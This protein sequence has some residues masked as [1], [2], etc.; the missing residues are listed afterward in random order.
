MRWLSRSF[1]LRVGWLIPALA[2]LTWVS[3]SVFSNY[4][5][6]QA[7]RSANRG[8][9]P[10]VRVHLGRFLA[11]H[12]SDAKARL[13]LAEAFLKDEANL[14]QQAAADAAL[15]E[16]ERI[17]DAS[18]HGPR[19]R[20]QEARLRLFVLH[21][22][23]AAEERLRRAILLDPKSG[24]APYLLWKLYDLT[25][26][27]DWADD[28][29][30]KSFETTPAP[31]RAE[32][33]REWYMSQFFPAYA[34]PE[35]DRLMGFLGEH[36]QP[37]VVSEFKR[38]Q[39]FRETEPESP[40][41]LAAVAKWFYVEGDPKFALQLLTEAEPNLRAPYSEPF[42]VAT[43]VSILIDLGELERAEA[44]FRRWPEPHAGYEFLKWQAIILDEVR[45]EFGQ[46][47]DIYGR[48]LAAWPG[49]ADWRLQYRK[50]QC[51]ARLGRSQEADALRNSARSIEKL[52]DRDY[53]SGLR[54]ALV[55]LT[56]AAQLEKIRTFYQELSCPKEV[57][58][59]SEVLRVLAQ[60][61]ASE[62]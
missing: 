11:I 40:V 20:I 57:H 26:R 2:V 28:A 33:L 18:P 24:E 58:A 51:L 10:Q 49:T 14:T 52:M 54:Q 4:Q 53:Q 13:L 46:A 41:A 56:D 32:R 21:Q 38:L 1:V 43:L 7:E 45:Q 42:Y 29:F 27:S 39:Y 36:D 8:R 55:Q 59:W 19:A 17:P 62:G 60:R 44:A 35:L 9:W 34:N 30:W 48:A 50:A 16:L 25:G 6:S 12:P 61:P 31:Q 23:R 47:L 5:W 3:V 15:R 22:P 37:S